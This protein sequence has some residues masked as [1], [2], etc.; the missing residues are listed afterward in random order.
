M[1]AG[2]VRFFAVS[3]VAA[4][5][6]VGS[7]SAQCYNPCAQYTNQQ[8]QACC[9]QNPNTPACD[10]RPCQP[11]PPTCA[12]TYAG[13]GEPTYGQ[14]MQSCCTTAPSN[15][16]S[17][18]N[19]DFI[20]FQNVAACGVC[21]PPTM[22]DYAYGKVVPYTGWQSKTVD[23]YIDPAI[24]TY[25]FKN[26]TTSAGVAGQIEDALNAIAPQLGFTFSYSSTPLAAGTGYTILLGSSGDPCDPTKTYDLECTLS[27]PASATAYAATGYA[28]TYIELPNWDLP[29]M[30]AASLAQEVRAIAR[31]E[32]LHTEG[33]ADD[34]ATPG[35]ASC[36][37]RTVMWFDDSGSAP[38]G[39]LPG[40][41][42]CAAANEGA[43]AGGSGG[44]G[45]G[46]G[47][48]APSGCTTPVPNSTCACVENASVWGWQCQCPG[49]PTLCAGGGEAVCQSGQWVCGSSSSSVGPY[50]TGTPPDCGPFGAQ[51][52]CEANPTSP[53]SSI[54]VFA[55]AGGACN[56]DT[57]LPGCTSET[58]NTSLGQLECAE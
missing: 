49:S 55:C 9:E 39:P 15:C 47:G 32:F 40:V 37:G 52:V 4:L 31:H 10:G 43:S 46:S 48:T 33:A 8:R 3:A 26:G 45:G 2:P 41:D 27:S 6:F 1:T 16:G 34:F 21:A 54:G 38:Q 5:T 7:A 13:L 11:P 53:G 35:G 24:D 17:S 50:C 51:A 30:T 58:C 19:S 56:G 44:G 28:I 36:A 25:T 14:D 20:V 29:G 57:A 12:Q 23:V 42:A 18:D 22:G